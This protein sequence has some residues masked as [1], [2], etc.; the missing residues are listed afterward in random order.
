MVCSCSS[1]SLQYQSKG[2]GSMH[3][4]VEIELRQSIRGLFRAFIAHSD[5]HA[6]LNF[7]GNSVKNYRCMLGAN[8]WQINKIQANNQYSSTFYTCGWY[9]TR[10]GSYLASMWLKWCLT[11]PPSW[12][13]I[14]VKKWEAG[15]RTK[16]CL[17]YRST[18]IIGELLFY[19]V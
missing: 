11:V 5:R 14:V 12:S 7:V 3:S 2:I 13:K 19:L 17:K 8:S 10:Y 4:L 18:T 9:I 1:F 6:C 15:L 16:Y